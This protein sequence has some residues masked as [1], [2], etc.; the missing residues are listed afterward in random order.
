MSYREENGLVQTKLGRRSHQSATS[1]A[2][3]ARKSNRRHDKS[4]GYSP[5]PSRIEVSVSMRAS[6][7]EIQSLGPERAK[8]FLGGIAAIVNAEKGRW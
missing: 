7:K 6:M 2:N 3:R 8:A 4:V 1:T 5:Q